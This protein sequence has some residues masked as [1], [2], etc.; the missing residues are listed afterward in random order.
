MDTGAFE[1]RFK[2]R[3]R[4]CGAVLPGGRVLAAV[5]GGADS[6]C[7][8]GLLARLKEQGEIRLRAVHVHHG[9]RGAEA[10]RDACWVENLCARIDI[11]IVSMK[12]WMSLPARPIWERRRP[13][14]FCAISALRKRRSGGNGE[15]GKG[16]CG[17]PLPTTRG[18]RRRQF[19][20]IFA[21]KRPKGHRRYGKAPWTADPAPFGGEQGGDFAVA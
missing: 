6:V 18:I 5:S 21:V 17:S 13:A 10:D 4:D 1:R 11:R 14:G 20:T 7:L 19:S 12:M 3:L 9:L 2:E 8:L 16:R 15:K